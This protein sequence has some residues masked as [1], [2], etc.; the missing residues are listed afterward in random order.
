MTCAG[1]QEVCP[2]ACQVEIYYTGADCTC[3]VCFDRNSLWRSWFTARCCV[4]C[5]FVRHPDVLFVL[6]VSFSY[7]TIF[8]CRKRLPNVH[9]SKF[10]MSICS[11][12]LCINNTVLVT[13]RGVCPE[14][15]TGYIQQQFQNI[16]NGSHKQNMGKSGM[17]AT[18]HGKNKILFCGNSTVGCERRRPLLAHCKDDAK[19]VRCAI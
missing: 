12:V 11:C 10:K 7:V 6:W 19:F 16:L 9:N 14:I 18:P 13:S 4:S 1:R 2:G 5:V 8:L 15:C 3:R 17:T